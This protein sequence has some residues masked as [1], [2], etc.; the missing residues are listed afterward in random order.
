MR[1]A[2]LAFIAVLAAG[3]AFAADEP[4]S[5]AGATGSAPPP[6]GGTATQI[7]QWIAD[8]PAARPGP[9]TEAMLAKEARKIHGEVGLTVGTAGYRSGYVVTHI[10][11]GES[12]EATIALSKTDYG[13]RARPVF[14]GRPDLGVPFN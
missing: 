7:Q 3:P 13:D 6:A 9:E 4:M 12:G 2:S 11:I 14:R 5:T 8:S 1:T 10:P